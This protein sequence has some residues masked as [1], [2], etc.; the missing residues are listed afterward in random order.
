MKLK[1]ELEKNVNLVSFEKNRIEIS[2]NDNLDKNFVKDLSLKLYEWTDQRWIIM[3]SKKKGDM[4]IKE[5]EYNNK[6]EL[7]DKAKNHQIYIE[8]KKKFSDANLIDV[9]SKKKIKRFNE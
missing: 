5:K 9:N 7:I 6:I 8:V 3:F 4:T 2:F 1:Y